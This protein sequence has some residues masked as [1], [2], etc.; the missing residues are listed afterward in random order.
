M[1]VY[2]LVAVAIDK[3]KRAHPKTLQA[4][5]SGKIWFPYCAPVC[6]VL[7]CQ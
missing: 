7:Y 1:L 3:F 4:F 6:H 2:A 5:E